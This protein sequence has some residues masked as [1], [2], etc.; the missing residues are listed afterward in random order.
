MTCDNKDR[1]VAPLIELGATM[2]RFSENRQSTEN[3]VESAPN[4]Q[5]ER[6]DLGGGGAGRHT[7]NKAI[8]LTTVPSISPMERHVLFPVDS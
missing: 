1:E 8:K 6:T 3:E 4:F 2:R 5:S 7:S